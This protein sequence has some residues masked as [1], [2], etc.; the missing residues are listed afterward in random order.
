MNYPAKRY[1]F[2]NTFPQV[3]AI[4]PRL[5][6]VALI[7]LA[8]MAHTPRPRMMV[9]GGC[10]GG[11]TYARAVRQLELAG[12]QYDGVF[13]NECASIPDV[14]GRFGI[15]AC[16]AGEALKAFAVACNNIKP[17]Q[18]Q[19]K[20]LEVMHKYNYKIHG[21][22]PGAPGDIGVPGLDT[23][24]VLK[25]DIKSRIPKNAFRSGHLKG[26]W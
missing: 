13:V 1:I 17:K 19:E 23:A 12:T 20:F 7:M 8:G 5:R 21:D 14:V 15:S 3:N 6:K 16:Q 2:P 18:Y 10:R 24:I 9:V 26:R 25:A 4:S 22:E 11:K